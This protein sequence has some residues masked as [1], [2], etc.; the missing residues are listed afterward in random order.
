MEWETDEAERRTINRR[1][2]LR[3]AGYLLSLLGIIAL[4]AWLVGAVAAGLQARRDETRSADVLVIVAPEL[5]T[6]EFIDYAFEVYRRGY[7]PEAVIVGPGSEAIRLGLIERGA[8]DR[9]LKVQT[10]TTGLVADLQTA[11]RTAQRAGAASALIIAD[12]AELLVWSKLFSDNG[13]RTYSATI[14]S[15]A[16]SPWQLLR[17]SARY[18][19]YALFRR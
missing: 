2:A 13:L 3:Q 16:P 7:A 18:W 6:P 8:A 11:A 15:A 14:R 12:P 10:P 1:R 9:T 17:G 5:P 19:R 4:T